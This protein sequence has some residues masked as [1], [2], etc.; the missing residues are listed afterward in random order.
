MKIW[1]IGSLLCADF[2]I[3]KSTTVDVKCQQKQICSSKTVSKE[4]K[5]KLFANVHIGMSVRHQRYI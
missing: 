4:E 1:L 3:F 5:N 2:R